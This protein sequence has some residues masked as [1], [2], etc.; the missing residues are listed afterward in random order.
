[1]AKGELNPLVGDQSILVTATANKA[2]GPGTIVGIWVS[3]TTSGT[4]ALYDSAT[5]ATTVKLMDTTTFSAVGFYP[6]PAK[7]GS[8]VYAVVGGT[9]SATLLLANP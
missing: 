4:L 2:T 6:F 1:M 7:Y 3:A 8:G 9:L 5:T